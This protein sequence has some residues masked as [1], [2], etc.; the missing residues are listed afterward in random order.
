LIYANITD[1]IQALVNQNVGNTATVASGQNYLYMT[2][3]SDGTKDSMVL[4][5]PTLMVIAAGVNDL[6]WSGSSTIV[7]LDGLSTT[8]NISFKASKTGL[9]LVCVQGDVTVAGTSTDPVKVW[10]L[11]DF[12]TTKFGIRSQIS[13]TTFGSAVVLPL[14]VGESFKVQLSAPSLQATAPSTSMYLAAT[15]VMAL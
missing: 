10:F 15:L 13:T 7:P 14:S 2:Y 11:T 6:D 12:E 3:L 5:N 8:D 1:T 9:W 4:S